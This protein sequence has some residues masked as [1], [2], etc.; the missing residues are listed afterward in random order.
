VKTRMARCPLIRKCNLK[1][2]FKHYNEVCTNIPKDAYLDCE[3]FKKAT[4]GTKIPMDWESL[5]SPV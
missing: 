4:T 3:E 5:T 1:V 2:G